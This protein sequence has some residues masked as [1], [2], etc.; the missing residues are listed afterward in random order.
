MTS[1]L[2]ISTALCLPAADITALIQGRIIAA[3]PKMF[4]RPSQKFALC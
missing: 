2:P 4:I 3:M 1:L